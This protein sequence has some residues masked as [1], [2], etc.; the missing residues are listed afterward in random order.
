MCQKRRARAVSRSQALGIPAPDARC[1]RRRR[2]GLC[3]AEKPLS[4]SKERRQRHPPPSEA[5]RVSRH[6]AINVCGRRRGV[7]PWSWPPRGG[8]KDVACVVT[9]DVT[10]GQVRHR[11]QQ[12]RR[13][14]I[15]CR[16]LLSPPYP[17]HTSSS[18]AEHEIE[19][20]FPPPSCYV[21]QRYQVFQGGTVGC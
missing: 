8:K 9:R 6:T 2:R 20:R 13:A 14:G 3:Y 16:C 7:P 15:L 17:S 21:S 11:G 1:R 10:Q 12:R 5:E 18:L 4:Q 19:R